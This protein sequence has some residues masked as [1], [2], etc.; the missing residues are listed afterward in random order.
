VLAAIAGSDAADIATSAA[1]AHKT[2]YLAALDA[3][4]LKGKR[5]GVLRFAAGWSARS[6]H[7]SNAPWKS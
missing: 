4:A 6:T 7:C 3:G 2:D 5:I 1:D